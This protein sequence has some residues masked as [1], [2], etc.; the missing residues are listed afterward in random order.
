MR[1]QLLSELET[2]QSVDDLTLWA[3]RRLPL[4]NRLTDPDARLVEVAYEGRLASA[5]TETD[6]RNQTS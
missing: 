3:L 2:L 5:H 6:E 4:K 1:G